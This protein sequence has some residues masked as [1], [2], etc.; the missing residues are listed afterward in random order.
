LHHVDASAVVPF[1]L[2]VRDFYANHIA[3]LKVSIQT[4]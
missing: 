2:T 1:V 4:R 3:R